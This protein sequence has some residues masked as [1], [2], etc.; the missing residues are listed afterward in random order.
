M[1]L[2][3]VASSFFPFPFSLPPALQSLIWV[4]KSFSQHANFASEQAHLYPVKGRLPPM[5]P[6]FSGEVS[7]TGVPCAFQSYWDCAD[8]HLKKKECRKDQ[9]ATSR[10]GSDMLSVAWKNSIAIES[11]NLWLWALLDSSC[12][13]VSTLQLISRRAA[14]RAMQVCRK[15]GCALK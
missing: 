2:A 1:L 4:E 13:R 7:S 3:I 14:C 11:G 8:S 6:H 10:N 9:A 12:A 15:A 5:W